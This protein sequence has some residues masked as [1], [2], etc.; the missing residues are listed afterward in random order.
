MQRL[1]L[2]NSFVA[3]D[4]SLC[5]PNGQSNLVIV[6]HSLSLLFCTFINTTAYCWSDTSIDLLLSVALPAHSQEVRLKHTPVVDGCSAENRRLPISA[7]MQLSDA[8]T[9]IK[10]TYI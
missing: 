7:E 8:D 5:L 6:L 9:C 3:G 1:T 10:C 4:E 2:M